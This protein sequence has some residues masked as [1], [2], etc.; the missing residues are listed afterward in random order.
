MKWLL[1][2]IILLLL[3][4]PAAASTVVL[5]S[6]QDEGIARY[7][8]NH[9]N[10]TLVVIPWGSGDRK[11]LE[12]LGTLNPD[13]LIIVGGPY[14][15]PPLFEVGNFKRYGGKDRVET[16]KIILRD[17]F[18]LD[19][20]ET[21]V[22]Y[23]SRE[24]VKEFIAEGG[25][26]ELI[27]ANTSVAL[28]WALLLGNE[29]PAGEGKKR[30][31]IGNVEN[32]P[33]MN[34]TWPEELPEVYS[35][36]PSIIVAN[37]TLFITGTDQNLPL[38]GRYFEE[39]TLFKR[40]DLVLLL[41][42]LAFITLSL[43]PLV[44]D[45]RWLGASFTAVTLFVFY[46]VQAFRL[47]WDTLFVYMDG[48]LSLTH[49]GTYETVVGSRGFPGLSYALLFA[50]RLFGVKVEAVI[51]YQII[52][53][54]LIALSLHM[55][56]KRGPLSTMALLLFLALP[57]FREYSFT[58]STELTFI[59]LLLLSLALLRRLPLAAS[60]PSALASMVRAQALLLPVVALMR[61]ERKGLV[62]AALSLALYALL[63]S[64]AGK[65][66]E[67]YM[68]EVSAKG[69]TAQTVLSNLSFYLPSIIKYAPIPAALLVYFSLRGELRPGEAL[70]L[71]I[72]YLF[73]PLLWV[74]QDERYLLPG[75]LL[76]LLAALELL[77]R[78]EEGVDG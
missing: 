59:A 36:Y 61:R 44:N 67:G 25:E 30:V 75:I 26:W 65:G 14:A 68:I 3:L 18:N 64:L 43:L 76:L 33:A 27:P 40:A 47:A 74:A 48:A 62:Y 31:F 52:L 6:D 55:H 21:I 42:F 38:I 7:L 32:N 9:L 4:P 56:F 20:P 51:L 73:L 23:P 16:A 72:A 10:A 8:A 28:R 46:N 66:F 63:Y 54:F 45:R 50:F 53:L 22:L 17:F 77:D 58:V 1:P 5:S 39:N 69:L 71:G 37:G 19:S 34:A 11:Y 13:E 35:L 29:L 70:A 2:V 49:S 78:A 24:A 57:L 60:L 12:E 41:S 15:V